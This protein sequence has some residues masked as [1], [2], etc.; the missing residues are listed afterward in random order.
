MV[1]INNALQKVLHIN[2]LKKQHESTCSTQAKFILTSAEK[3]KLI[4]LPKNCIMLRWC[5]EDSSPGEKKV[6]SITNLIQSCMPE[7]S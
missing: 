4:S 3:C 7:D 5:G 6:F 1:N 2:E